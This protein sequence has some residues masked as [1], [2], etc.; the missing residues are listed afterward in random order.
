MKNH[1][2][3]DDVG[4]WLN[5]LRCAVHE[6]FE[7]NLEK[8]G[9]SIPQWCILISVYN[10]DAQNITQLSDYIQVDKA[11]IS[12]V[13]DRL[14]NK[15]LI[16]RKEGKDRRSVKLTLSTE[17]NDLTSKLI[18][19]A[20]ENEGEFFGC[21]NEGEKDLLRDLFSK[22]LKGANVVDFEGWIKQ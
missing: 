16:L 4:Y 22:L 20:E 1:S 2:L 7:N 17:G 3:K 19:V 14:V 18:I 21:L 9:I 10:A 12:R 13:V 5:R 8:Y 15:G 11:T 6:S